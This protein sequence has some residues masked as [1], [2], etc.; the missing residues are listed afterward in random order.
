VVNALL[1]L[2]VDGSWLV[3]DLGSQN[4]TNLNNENQPLAAGQTRTLADGDQVHV[5]G[6][7]TI[8]LHAPS[9]R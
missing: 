6:W 5:G 7:T 9:A 3:A 8:T 1:T 4:E 2:S